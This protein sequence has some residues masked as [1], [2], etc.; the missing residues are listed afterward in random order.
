MNI[1]SGYTESMTEQGA[2]GRD[3][4]HVQAVAYVR[5][6]SEEQ[7]RHG[8]SLDDQ[9]RELRIQIGLKGWELVEVGRDEGLSGADPSRPGLRRIEELASE[10]RCDV[11]LATKR[12]RWFRDIEHRR[13]YERGLR[14]MGTRIAALND[15][16]NAIADG[17]D[18]LLGEE[19][20][21]DI[22]RETRRGRRARARTGEV[23]AGVAPFGFR[24]T[25]DRKN[26]EVEEQEAAVVLRV[27]SLAASGVGLNGVKSALQAGGVPTPR[28][29]RGARGTGDGVTWSRAV[30][31][32]MVLSECYRPHSPEEL[33]ALVGAGN[34][35]ETVAASASDPA[36]VWWFARRGVEKVYDE[37]EGGRRE[38]WDNPDEEHIAVPIPDLGVPREQVDEARR[39]VLTN[40]TPSK[41]SRRFWELS[42]GVLYCPCARRMGTHTAKR[43]AGHGFYYVCGLR[44]SNQG[45][46]E[47][48]AKYHRAG[49]T[50]EKVRELVLGLLSRPEEVRRRAEEY[51]RAE[52]ERI[53]GAGRDLAAREG[54]LRKLQERRGALIDLAA[55]GTITRADLKDRLSAL[56]AE[57][58][59]HGRELD[60]LRDAEEE[61]ERLRELPAL[62]E[63][64]ARD[65][66]YLL[67]RTPHVRDYET[68][69]EERTEENPLGIYELAP[70]RIRR[71]PEEEVEEKRR[72]FE[73]ARSARFRAMYDDLGLRVV[74]SPDGTLQASWRFGEAVLRCNSDKSKNKHAT[75]HFQATEHPLIQSFQPGEDWIWCYVDEIL[76]EPAN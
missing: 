6:S 1:R 26:F 5:V 22:A 57:R 9:E 66:P 16:G 45:R 42:G 62:A 30:L 29:F 72:R 75:K 53:E 25:P 41:A 60:A 4:V 74:A 8:Y 18:D 51:V 49:E 69:P 10:E 61:A 63:S 67:E 52:R 37:D 12:N 71:L 36:G 7:R 68:V 59:G 43:K 76:M 27:F 31:R 23:V 48:G 47:H 73:D 21:R 13:R 34:L 70:E 3:D 64:L 15:S 40:R 28:G 65:L 44:R 38:F 11:A 39:R 58:E 32:Q 54:R 17:V 14:R 50:E 33:A 24:F 20:R 46:C 2:R 35:D 19:Q 56:D 55:D